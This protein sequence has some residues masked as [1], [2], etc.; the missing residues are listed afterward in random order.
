[1][2]NPH[3]RFGFHQAEAGAGV[4]QRHLLQG[5]R[6]VDP[7]PHDAQPLE[8]EGALAACVKGCLVLRASQADMEKGVALTS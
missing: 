2:P 5:W 1:M 6:Q 8:R 4:P 7:V 3:Q